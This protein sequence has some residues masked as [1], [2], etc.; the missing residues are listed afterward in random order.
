MQKARFTQGHIFGILKEHH[1][2]V[3]AAHLYRKHGISDVNC[4][5][6]CRDVF[7]LI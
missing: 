7:Y 1:A 4:H 5:G 3:L 6:F 2:S